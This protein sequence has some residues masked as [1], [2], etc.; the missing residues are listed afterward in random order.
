M[1][2][3]LSAPIFLIGSLLAFNTGGAAVICEGEC[4]ATATCTDIFGNA[5][6]LRDWENVWINEGFASYCEALWF[7]HQSGQ[8]ADDDTGRGAGRGSHHRAP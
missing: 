8:A 7:E 3:A 1:L 5:V 4:S 2:W 6:T